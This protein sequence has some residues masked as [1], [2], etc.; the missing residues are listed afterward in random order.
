MFF[1]LLQNFLYSL[2]LCSF[3]FNQLYKLLIKFINTQKAASTLENILRET[4]KLAW[5]I[6]KKFEV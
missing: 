6:Y 5:R 1:F 3:V 4:Y 2:H